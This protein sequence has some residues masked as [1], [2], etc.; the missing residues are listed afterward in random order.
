MADSGTTL[1][2]YES[3]FWIRFWHRPVPTL[4]EPSLQRPDLGDQRSQDHVT[5]SPH[6]YFL[7][8]PCPF[9]ILRTLPE[10]HI[11]PTATFIN[12][13]KWAVVFYHPIGYLPLRLF[14][15]LLDSLFQ[16][17]VHF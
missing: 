5:L 17:R 2:S 11:D 6:C 13:P 12:K 15:S 16:H 10:K 4:I 7:E 3:H 9:S 8:A 1:N 14:C